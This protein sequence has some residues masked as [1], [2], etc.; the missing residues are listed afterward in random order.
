[1]PKL[2]KISTKSINSMNFE[3]KRE[4]ISLKNIPKIK[5]RRKN[6]LCHPF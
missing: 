4:P 2:H 1:M 6:E 5:I 3:L